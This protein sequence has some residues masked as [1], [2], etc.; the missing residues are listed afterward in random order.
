MLHQAFRPEDPKQEATAQMGCPFEIV[1]ELVNDQHGWRN[2]ETD[3]CSD[4]YVIGSNMSAPAGWSSSLK[5]TAHCI[6]GGESPNKE[7]D[8]KLH[9][10]KRSCFPPGRGRAGLEKGETGRVN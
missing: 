2:C 8:P 6:N 10:I 7:I 9:L 5:N 3:A 1:Q 4:A